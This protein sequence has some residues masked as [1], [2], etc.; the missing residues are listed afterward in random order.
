MKE[1][2]P[3]NTCLGIRYPEAIPERKQKQC[4]YR[5]QEDNIADILTYI[6]WVTFPNIH[7]NAKDILITADQ[8]RLEDLANECVFELF[9]SVNP[10]NVAD[11]LSLTSE[12]S[13]YGE[14]L[15]SPCNSLIKKNSFC[16]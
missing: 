16:V 10:T 6:Y 3:C 13:V 1:C 5:A 14:L 2:P 15:E 8:F 11:Y 7:N 9:K 12:L 4:N